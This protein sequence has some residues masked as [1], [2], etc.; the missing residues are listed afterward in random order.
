MLLTATLSV[1]SSISSAQ[2]TTGTRGDALIVTNNPLA[3][4]YIATFPDTPNSPVRGQVH[5][6]TV[7]NGTGIRFAVAISGLP[8]NVGAFRKLT[9]LRL[10]NAS[11][12][13]AIFDSLP[14][15]RHA[16]PCRWKLQWYPRPS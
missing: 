16:S 1:L 3:A 15:S 8:D 7:L 2:S 13:Q 12:N 11:S 10:T 5:A 14:H 4:Q 6:E 9:L